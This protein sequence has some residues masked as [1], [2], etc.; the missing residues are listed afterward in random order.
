MP[1]VTLVSGA[2]RVSPLFRPVDLVHQQGLLVLPIIL[3]W[4]KNTY[5]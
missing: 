2:L 4:F 1:G 3:F 5:I